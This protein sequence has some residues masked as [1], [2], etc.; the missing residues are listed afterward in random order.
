MTSSTASNPI[1]QSLTTREYLNEFHKLDFYDRQEPGT[2]LMLNQFGYF[3][4]DVKKINTY[5]SSLHMANNLYKIDKICLHEDYSSIYYS[6]E[7]LIKN[8][9]HV[10]VIMLDIQ[11]IFG[12]CLDVSWHL[13]SEFTNLK[14]L[15]IDGCNNS[16]YYN[17]SIHNI[18]M[19]LPHSL[20]ALSIVNLPYYNEPFSP[21][22]RT[23][24]LKI[25]KL[26]TLKFNQELG[27]LPTTLE[28]LIIESGAFNQPMINLPNGL[29][30]LILLCPI[31]A[32]PLDTLPHGLEYFAGLHFNCFVYP[33]N[34]YELELTNLPSSI[35]TIV[36]DKYLY[37]QKD[38]LNQ[39]YKACKII[40]YEDI[41]NFEFI[42]NTLLDN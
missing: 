16:R 40:C 26:M 11:I 17:K 27:N 12:D 5:T 32:M 23:S 1:C 41:N 25:I 21:Q 38:I 10:Q 35:K 42:I 24:N 34:T 29:K 6:L 39:I 2:E 14:L 22:I 33:E 15:Y 37:T 28:T 8:G 4:F 30:H 7:S 3:M 13:L 9:L 20:E 18:T 19:H 31:F 36:L